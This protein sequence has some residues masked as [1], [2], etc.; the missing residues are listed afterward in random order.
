MCSREKVRRVVCVL[1]AVW[2]TNSHFDSAVCS[3]NLYLSRERFCWNYFFF[4]PA[5]PCSHI[6]HWSSHLGAPAT[7]TEPAWCIC[8]PRPFSGAFFFH[9]YQTNTPPYSAV[10]FSLSTSSKSFPCKTKTRSL[11]FQLAFS[12]AFRACTFCSSWNSP[13]FALES[14]DLARSGA[15]LATLSDFWLAS[16]L[17]APNL[18]AL[19]LT[20]GFLFLERHKLVWERGRGKDSVK[21]FENHWMAFLESCR[22]L[23]LCVCV[24]ERDR[25]DQW[26]GEASCKCDN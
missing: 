17:K 20:G 10:G 7:G 5:T 3:L 15:C 1:K 23:L 11:L 9:L 25:G 4:S 19:N 22:L 24:R 18:S 13:T 26:G 2:G 16:T 21:G 14:V 12:V 8:I 6:Q